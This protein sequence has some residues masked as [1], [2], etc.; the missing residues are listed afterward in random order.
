MSG[1]DLTPELL[2]LTEDDATKH[3]IIEEVDT[4]KKLATATGNERHLPAMENLEEIALMAT[5][6]SDKEE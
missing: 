2:G 1:E 5:D 3:R 4:M 6:N